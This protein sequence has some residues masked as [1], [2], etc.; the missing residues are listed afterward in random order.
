MGI[1][2][3]SIRGE[4]VD[5]DLI[6]MKQQLMNEKKTDPTIQRESY[7]SDRRRRSSSKRIN[8]MLANQQM[9]KQKIKEQKLVEEMNKEFP[10]TDDFV[11][12][13]QTAAPSAET[14]DDDKKPKIVR[15]RKIVKN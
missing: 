6:K 11:D 13:E 4:E 7:V 15:N 14:Q 2:K 8:E 9:V 12:H 10:D 1:K 3:R 5:I